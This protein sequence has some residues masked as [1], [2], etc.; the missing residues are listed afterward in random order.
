MVREKR[1]IRCFRERKSSANKVYPKP[2]M[3]HADQVTDSP[4]TPS[5]LDMWALV[6]FGK[7][8]TVTIPATTRQL[9]PEAGRFL[10]L[11]M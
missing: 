1:K 10:L 6:V 9:Y 8:S 3:H 5:F 7:G 2:G 4:P 11:P